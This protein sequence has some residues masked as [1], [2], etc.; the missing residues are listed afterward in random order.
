MKKNPRKFTAP[1][2]DPPKPVL[3]TP[4]DDLLAD[5]SGKPITTAKAWRRKRAGILKA[6][7]STLGAFPKT[8]PPLEAREIG[9]EDLPLFERRK[10]EIRVHPDEVMTAYLCLPK[11]PLASGAAVLCLPQTHRVAHEQMAGLHGMGPDAYGARLAAEGFVTLCPEHFVAGERT[12]R[13]G[14][15]VTAEFYE[16]YP[17]WSA[18]G[19]ALWDGQFGVDYLQSLHGVKAGRIGCMGHS[20]GGHGSIFLAAVDER[21]QC[22]VSNC[23]LNSFRCNP[24]RCHWSR[25]GWYVYFPVLRE[26]FL[27]GKPAPFDFHELGAAL[28]PRAWLDV[29]SLS[30]PTFDGGEHLPGMLTRV[31]DVYRL[32][33]VPER[34]AFYTHGDPHGMFDHSYALAAAWLKRWLA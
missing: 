3:V 31:R 2:T 17:E 34:L 23:G 20:L 15:F 19:K 5:L 33:G 16:K 6:F 7:R 4:F 13:H 28:A 24:Q 14:A 29:S 11:H 18:V 25:D 22:A 26:L 10:V 21:I 8:R 32:L 1:I 27:K 12:P 9:R 30:D